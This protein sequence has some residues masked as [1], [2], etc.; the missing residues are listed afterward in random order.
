MASDIEIAQAATLRPIK[1]IAAQLNIQEDD[2]IPYGRYKA[3]L[4]LDLIDLEKVKKTNSSW[5][6]PYP[7]LRPAKEKPRCP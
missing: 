2:L 3:K 7:L 4:P 6:R 5:Y 1:Q